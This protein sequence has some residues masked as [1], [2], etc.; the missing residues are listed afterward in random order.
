M[1]EIKKKTLWTQNS[2]IE[3]LL[4]PYHLITTNEI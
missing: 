1:N 4:N 3:P 2:N